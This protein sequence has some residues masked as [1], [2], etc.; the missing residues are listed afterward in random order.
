MAQAITGDGGRAI[1]TTYTAATDMEMLVQSIAFTVATG[2][3][4]GTHYASVTLR[5]QSDDVY[6]TAITDQGGP[7]GANVDYVFALGLVKSDFASIPPGTVMISAP[8]P[9]IVMPAGSKIVI[10]C[11]LQGASIAPNDRIDFV[12]IF[13][14]LIRVE[15]GPSFGVPDPVKGAYTTG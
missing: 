11:Q 8:L 14:D 12:S 4:S 10:G 5:S 9:E 3:E 13:A 1:V 7:G 2:G 6:A 15:D